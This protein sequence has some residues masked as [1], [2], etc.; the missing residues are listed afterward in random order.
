MRVVL[1]TKLK[2]VCQCGRDTMTICYCSQRLSTIPYNVT[3]MVSPH[4]PAMP[5]Q[6]L[7]RKLNANH[8]PLKSSTDGKP[9]IAIHGF[10]AACSLP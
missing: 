5:L 4:M 9:A 3:N 1:V 7:A 8:M 6:L 2:Q 10:R